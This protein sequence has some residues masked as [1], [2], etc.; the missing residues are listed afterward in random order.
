MTLHWSIG[1]LKITNQTA[2]CFGASFRY[3]ISYLHLK[4]DVLSDIEFSYVLALRFSSLTFAAGTVLS[5]PPK[6]ASFSDSHFW[7]PSES[8]CCQTYFIA[9]LCDNTKASG[10]MFVDSSNITIPKVRAAQRPEWMY[11]TITKVE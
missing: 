8:D 1:D 4:P 2:W 9:S 3:P 10:I 11:S 6:D 5:D 7:R